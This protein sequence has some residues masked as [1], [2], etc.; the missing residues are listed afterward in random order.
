VIMKVGLQMLPKIYFKV[1]IIGPFEV[2]YVP[3]SH[4]RLKRI[5]SHPEVTCDYS[6]SSE[7]LDGH[8]RASGTTWY[9]FRLPRRYEVTQSDALVLP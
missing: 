6:E 7:I 8:L 5:G 1:L 2:A 3:L 4:S 9:N